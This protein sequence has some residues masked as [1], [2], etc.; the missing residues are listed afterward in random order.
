[1]LYFSISLLLYIL[2]HFFST[3]KIKMHNEKMMRCPYNSR[4]IFA[5]G[6]FYKHINKCKDKYKSGIE[7]HFCKANSMVTYTDVQAHKLECR[8]CGGDEPQESTIN[9]SKYDASSTKINIDFNNTTYNINTHN[10]LDELKREES[11]DNSSSID[12]SKTY[13]PEE[14]IRNDKPTQTNVKEKNNNSIYY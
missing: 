13:N 5:Q 12:L 6:K 10:I 1:M 8:Y 3:I 2:T 7:I 14:D 11:K 9:N 4:H